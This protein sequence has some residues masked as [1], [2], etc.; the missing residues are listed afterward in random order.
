MLH[1]TG[2][3]RI[4]LALAHQETDLVPMHY[5][6]L[7]LPVKIKLQE[8]LGLPSLAAVEIYLKKYSD[9][10]GFDLDYIGPHD[11]EKMLPDRKYRDIWGVVREPVSY[12]AGS[13]DEI[14]H[15]PL[16]NI[17][18]IG[19]LSNFIWPEPAWWRYDNLDQKIKEINKEG[20]AVLAANGNIFESSWYMRGFEKMLMDL[21][22]QP[23]LANAIMT[24]VTDY[25][26]AYFRN[27]L[28]AARGQIDIVFTADD[29]GAQEGLLMSRDLWTKMIKP[30]HIRLNRALHEFD[31]AVM[32]HTDGAV[33]E[34]IPDLIDMG[35]D[36]LQPLQFDAKGMDPERLKTLYGDRLCFY[37]GVS[38]QKTL[39]FGTVQDVQREV[40]DRKKVLGAN[41]GYILAPSHAI[42]AG[43]PP[44]NIVAFLE[45]GRQQFT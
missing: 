45:S 43:T 28:Q 25:F 40:A 16:G 26:I 9:I 19:E 23:E 21:I 17:E 41:G 5:H 13:Y 3:E 34:I 33:M 42:Q 38:V 44:E 22:E 37:G 15:Y 39:P 6:Y 14:C 18:N 1:L 30:H 2:R 20:R 31:V 36:I 27:M 35:I 10:Q 4:K 11:R 7:N 32:Y 24:K 29:L 8:Y 12:G